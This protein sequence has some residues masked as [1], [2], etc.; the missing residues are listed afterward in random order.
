MDGQWFKR[1]GNLNL[2]TVWSN[3]LVEQG[4]KIQRQ[5]S[6]S[7]LKINRFPISLKQSFRFFV[8]LIYSDFSSFFFQLC[9]EA[10]QS[11]PHGGSFASSHNYT[12]GN[13]YTL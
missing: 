1:T 9:Y 4:K 8:F 6:P 11:D 3:M 10:T 5:K 12:L 13:H 2:S 7:F